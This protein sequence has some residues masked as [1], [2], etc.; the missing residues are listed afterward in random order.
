MLIL[1]WFG[2]VSALITC[3]MITRVSRLRVCVITHLPT[4]DLHNQMALTITYPLCSNV[5]VMSVCLSRSRA[6]LPWSRTAVDC[7]CRPEPS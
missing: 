3:L 5:V 7:K 2:D 6:C 1:G 4:M